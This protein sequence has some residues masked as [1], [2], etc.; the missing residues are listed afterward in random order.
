MFRLVRIFVGLALIYLFVAVII[1]MYSRAPEVAERKDYTEADKWYRPRVERGNERIQKEPGDRKK[2]NPTAE[3]VSMFTLGIDE[4]KRL[5]EEGNAEA[6]Y[7]LALR[8]ISGKD[9]D[10]D[11]AEVAKW[12]RKAAEQGH[13][14]SQLTLGEMYLRGVGVAQDDVEATKWFQLAAEQGDRYGQYMLGLAYAEGKGVPKNNSEAIKWYRMAAEQ[15]Y[16]DAKK[17]LEAMEKQAP[18]SAK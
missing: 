18:P 11:Y 9:V 7:N 10:K 2:Q 1:L 16:V 6:Q 4:L 17:A 13:I 14:V 15:G 12:H 8:Y 3:K 5:A